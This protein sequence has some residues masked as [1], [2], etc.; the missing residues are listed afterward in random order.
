MNLQKD[1]LV[2]DFSQL[3]NVVNFLVFV[4]L[5]HLLKYQK[6]T[7]KKKLVEIN[8]KQFL[9]I[10]REKR[11]KILRKKLK[12]LL[13]TKKFNKIKSFFKT[14]GK[15]HSISSKRKLKKMLKQRVLIKGKN[16][17]YRK[18]KRFS[19]G[20]FKCCS[21]GCNLKS[22]PTK[23]SK[24]NNTCSWNRISKKNW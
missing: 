23:C 11:R 16:G 19:Y 14:Y 5:D 7:L 18:I 21:F 13:Y 4:I 8:K 12:S 3:H 6:S 20:R 2:L 24:I 1:I 9:K 17:H 15:G 22:K 10:H